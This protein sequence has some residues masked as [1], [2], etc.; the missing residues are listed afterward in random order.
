MSRRAGDRGM[1]TRPVL[2][3]CC[4]P[5]VGNKSHDGEHGRSG[6]AARHRDRLS[7]EQDVD[8]SAE[9]AGA[10]QRPDRNEE[11]QDDRR[12]QSHQKRCY[13][14]AS[15]RSKDAPRLHRLTYILITAAATFLS[16]G[17]DGKHRDH[18]ER[19][20]EHRGNVQDAAYGLYLKPT[21]RHQVPRAKEIRARPSYWQI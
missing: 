2:G 6:H 20:G 13:Q 16:G 17:P 10:C 3:D 4:R 18:R 7:G 12:H 11:D 5:T 9:S 14:R 1:P 8:R 15:G 19:R 21:T